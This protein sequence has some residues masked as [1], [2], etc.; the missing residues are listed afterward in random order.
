M[1]HKGPVLRLRCIG[2]G[3][4]LTQIPF[5]S[6]QTGGNYRVSL[7]V[8]KR[9]RKR[10]KEREGDLDTFVKCLQ[11]PTASLEAQYLNCYDMNTQT[12]IWHARTHRPTYGMHEHT[13]QHMACTNTQTNIW[14]ARTHRPTYCM[15]EHTDQHTACTNTQTNIPHAWTHRPTYGMHIICQDIF[16]NNIWYQNTIVF[17]LNAKISYFSCFLISNNFHAFPLETRDRGFT[18]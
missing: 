9:E 4:A 16:E 8:R 14:H 11:M 7:G 1:W 12:N 13:D 18:V 3:R 15:H 17:K 10:D 6:I 5:N 2:P